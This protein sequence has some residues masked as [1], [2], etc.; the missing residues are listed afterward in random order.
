MADYNNLPSNMPLDIGSLENWLNSQQSADASWN[1]FNQGPLYPGPRVQNPLD[2]E[3][4]GTVGILPNVQEMEIQ[5]WFAANP[6]ATAQDIFDV[7]QANDISPE[8]VI[9]AMGFDPVSAMATY[10]TF[11]QAPA[12]PTAPTQQADT[13]VLDTLLGGAKDA[14]T[15]V[16]GVIDA[17]LQQLGAL[18]GMGDPSLVVLNP[19]N[20]TASVVYGTPTGN[21]TPTIIGSM[22]NSGAPVG[23][24]TGIPALDNILAGVFSQRAS[25]GS[26]DI[27]E[28]IREAVLGTISS[29]T[30]YPVAGVAGAV[31][32]GLSGDLNKVVDS[33]SKVVLQIDK[34]LEDDVNVDPLS[35]IKGPAQVG[36]MGPTLEELKTTP[37][38]ISGPAQVGEMGPTL[39]ELMTKTTTGGV[40]NDKITT[41]GVTNDKITTGG[42]TNDKIT[43]GGVT[44]DKITTGGVTNDKIT[45][46]GVTNDVVDEIKTILGETPD[47]KITTVAPNVPVPTV[48]TPLYG[49]GIRGMRTEKAGVTPIEDVFDISDLSL[50]NVLSLLAGEGDNTQRAPYYGGGTVDSNVDEIIRLLRG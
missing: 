21:A 47:N 3:G 46:G 27:K 34:K 18:I 36:K 49:Q 42:V 16:S 25:Q 48:A 9:S 44:N 41:G 38:S 50:A 23:V 31:E 24:I 6:D 19:V 29:E 43:T 26:R 33:V 2:T 8:A 1:M 39:E 12:A 45:T 40:T 4:A 17:G 13:G 5:S 15:A 7:M 32:G 22:P 28:I 30:G 11:L 20:P 37:V 35:I 14:V 10:N